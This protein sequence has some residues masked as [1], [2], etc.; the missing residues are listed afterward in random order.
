MKNSKNAGFDLKCR[1]PIYPEFFSFI[2][3]ELQ[4]KMKDIE[5]EEGTS[6]RGVLEMTL[7]IDSLFK[8]AD[9]VI[10]SEI[11]NRALIR[12]RDYIKRRTRV[13]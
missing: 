5:N 8:N 9:P 6:K 1:F 12:K 2:S 10:V 7:N 11:L 4:E 13:I 3:K